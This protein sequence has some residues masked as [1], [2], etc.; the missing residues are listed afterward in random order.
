M[1]TASITDKFP[2][3]ILDT[4]LADLYAIDA[5][6]EDRPKI[7]LLPWGWLTTFSFG[8]EYRK[9]VKLVMQDFFI[10]LPEPFELPPH[11]KKLMKVGMLNLIIQRDTFAA[12]N[13]DTIFIAFDDQDSSPP[14][15][16]IEVERTVSALHPSQRMRPLY[17]SRP[18]DLQAFVKEQGID[19]LAPKFFHDDLYN[20]R[21]TCDVDTL[22]YINS[23]AAIVTSGLPTPKSSIIQLGP[24]GFDPQK[25]CSHCAADLEGI[26]IPNECVGPRRTWI[27]R[28]IARASARIRARQLPF[29]LKLQMS[30]SGK[31][32]FVVTSEEERTELIEKLEKNILMKMLSWLIPANA[33]LNSASLVLMDYISDA[34]GNWGVT[35]FVTQTG[36]SIFLGASEQ[37]LKDKVRW[38]GS[39]IDYLAQER[40]KFRFTP[41]MNQIGDWLH[42]YG[43]YGP[44][45]ADILESPSGRNGETATELYVVDLNVRTSGSLNIVLLGNHFSKQR[46]LHFATSFFLE[47]EHKRD[48]IMS[49]FS[50]EFEEGRI[51][52][53]AWYENDEIGAAAAVVIAGE[54]HDALNKTVREFFQYGREF[55]AE[56]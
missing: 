44:I 53:T 36:K 30:A 22:Y 40:L 3:I 7:A 42:S 11:M 35:F 21:L 9:A 27:N 31:G 29:V 26:Q 43:Y 5:K 20:H 23:K 24:E 8:P 39:T 17:I 19:L 46:G 48:F 52:I 4:T 28:N 49:K 55:D 13:M 54:D 45:G 33:H 34:V 2:P 14:R 38:K 47:S 12:G 41:V 6:D 18:R 51:V 1:T 50:R 15:S 25:C 10:D 16:K 32:T 56:E 37:R